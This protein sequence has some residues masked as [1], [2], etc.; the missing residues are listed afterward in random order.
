M[1]QPVSF[2]KTLMRLLSY[3]RDW[4]KP[5][6]M[7]VF[8]LVMASA[9]QVTGPALVSYF[10][11][12][13]I[14]TRQWQWL[15][16]LALGGGFL[17]LQILAAVFNYRQSLL[18]NR[19]AIG[20]VR[21]IRCEVMDAALRQP[22]SAF[23]TRPVGQ[24]VSRV[25]NDSE[26]VRDLYIS[27]VGSVLRSGVLIISMLVAMF[28]L[29]WRM[30]L[31]AAGI[32]PLVIAV[33]II[34]QRYSTGIARQVRTFLADINNSLNEVISG[35]TVIQQFRRQK[36][37]AE[38]LRQHNENHYQAR[39]KILRLD[40]FLLRPLLNLFSAIILSLLVLLFSLS[41]P[42]HFEVGVL[43]AFIAYLGRIEEPLIELTTRQSLLQQAVV[44]AERIFELMDAPAQQYGPDHRALKTGA[45]TINNLS[46]A[47]KP[48]QPVLKNIHCRLSSGGFLAL[49]GHT[50]SGKSTL[51]G[52]L[53]GY[54]PIAEGEITLDGRKISQLSH[55]VLR[56]GIGMVQQDPVILADTLLEN[57]CLGREIS[58]SKVMAALEQVKLMEWFQSLPEGLHTRMGEQGKSLSAG[59]KQLLA[60]ARILVDIPVLLILDE[61]TAS[62]DSGTEQAIQQVLNQIRKNTTLVVIAHRLSTI[63]AAD[64]IL[65]LERGE[66]IE[67]GTHQQLLDHRGRYRQMYQL[68]QAGNELSHRT[69]DF[70]ASG[71]ALN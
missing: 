19:V 70:P 4:K 56:K 53:M 3:G 2:M 43:Y 60:L 10:I 63:T 37:F 42:G 68:Q 47:Y 61:A 17:L 30:A 45:L 21:K 14:S 18:F 12:H 35:M 15:P 7:A 5:L 8:L 50:G 67:Q 31:I 55:A 44:S 46:F 65:V 66:V 41:A 23:D 32:F 64:T 33:M 51:A 6:T 28:I 16:V 69:A 48:G 11:D 26:V 54:Y 49:V 71:N 9:T 24:L 29:D 39:M 52:L 25:T 62:I 40:A 13:F 22:L 57:I 58:A 27:V 1:S 20:V 38:Q 34:Y 36:Y 59:Q